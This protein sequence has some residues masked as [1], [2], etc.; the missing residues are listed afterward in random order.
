MLGPEGEKAF[1]KLAKSITLAEIPL[2]KT[3]KLVDD[4]WQ[5][6]KNTAKWQLSSSVIHGFMGALQSA[7]GYAQDL[8]SSLNDIRIV[9]EMSTD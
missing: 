3:N 7:Y 5:S 1:L 6:L 4:L 8:N 2:K 9:T